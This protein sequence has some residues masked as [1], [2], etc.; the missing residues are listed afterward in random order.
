MPADAPRRP[1]AVVDVVIP[2]YNEERDL[3]PSITTLVTYL[4]AH[5]TMPFRVLIADNASIDGTERVGRELAAQHDEVE[6]VRL[7]RK[8]RGG[9]LKQVWLDSPARYVTYMDVDLSTN[10]AAF[11]VLLDLL[12]NGADVA[13]GSRLSPDAATTRS[14]KREILSRGYNLL[15]KAFFGTCFTDAQCGFKGVRREAVQALVPHVEDRKWF[16]DTE[17]LILAEKSGRSVGEVPV[18]WIEDLD[19]RVQLLR[20]I[21]DDLV[22]LVR[23]RRTLR[24]VL[25][26]IR[27]SEPRSG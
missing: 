22:A 19:T 10:L 20:T 21:W 13:I 15:V 27:E 11:P 26:R 1:V 18:D 7:P 23:L 25:R 4:R 9:A 8:G 6:Y 3:P 5:L 24:G 16:F 2:V 14:L 17:L 12:A